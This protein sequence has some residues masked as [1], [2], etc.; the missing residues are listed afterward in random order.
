MSSTTA[1]MTLQRPQ[2]D[3]PSPLIGMHEAALLEIEAPIKRGLTR[4]A[5]W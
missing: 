2:S 4:L 5:Q 1:T 3:N